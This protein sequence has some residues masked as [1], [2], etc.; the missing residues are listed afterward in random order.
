MAR[1][2]TL[3]LLD[4]GGTI[5]KVHVGETHEG[6]PE[7]AAFERVLIEILGEQ[8]VAGRGR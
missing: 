8:P 3:Y 2:P 1:L 4:R 7:A 6:S 5:R